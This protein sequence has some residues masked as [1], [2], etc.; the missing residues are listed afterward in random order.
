[1]VRLL[2]HRSRGQVQVSQ[3]LSSGVIWVFHPT[4]R[5]GVTSERESRRFEGQGRSLFRANLVPARMPD[6]HVWASHLCFVVQHSS[7]RN[8]AT[9][10]P[11]SRVASRVGH[12]VVG[13]GVRHLPAGQARERHVACNVAFMAWAVK[14]GI[15]SRGDFTRPA[16]DG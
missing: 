2:E 6:V 15:I 1:M 9:G 3:Q 10:N 8:H 7:F 13:A 16:P 4:C 12:V 14:N 11:R 5:N